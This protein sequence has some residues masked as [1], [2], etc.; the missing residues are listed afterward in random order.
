M[1]VA[2]ASLMKI[3]IPSHLTNDDLMAAV[4]GLAGEERDVTA[5]LI[6]H[7]AEIDARQLYVPDGYSSLFVYC[8]EG[9]GYSEDAAYNRK[10]AA[11]LARRYPA[12][13]DMLAD[14]RLSLTAVRLLAP[15]LNE[16]N[17]QAAVAEASGKSKRDV[18]K[19]VAQLEPRPGVPSTIRKLPTPSAA[20]PERE[21][22]A[23][24]PPA[25]DGPAGEGAPPIGESSPV[26]TAKRPEVAPLTRER[27]RVQFTIGDETERK[28]RRIQELL[29]RE[30]P[31]GDPAVIFDRALDVLLAK[32]ESRKHGVT[33]NPRASRGAKEGS[34]RTPAAVRREVVRRDGGQCTFRAADG[35]RCTERAY[36]EYHHGR[37]PYGHGGEA[38]AE[39]MALHCRTHNA[40]EGRMTFG[41]RAGPE[42]RAGGP[43]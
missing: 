2:Q 37:V 35:R 23:P 19:L 1:S 17:W 21:G 10:A 28:L 5:R 3:M 11:Q 39:N 9:L 33:A 20:V 24:G 32:V 25:M 18:E 29:K 16:G 36:I 13:L 41:A 43:M 14:G 27:Y 12:I 42:R 8:H 6:A 15:V 34:R 26:A 40:Y 31:D 22:G 38:T 4:V 30:I 7:L